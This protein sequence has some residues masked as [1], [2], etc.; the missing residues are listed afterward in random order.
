MLKYAKLILVFVLTHPFYGYA[1]ETETEE[2]LLRPS[3]PPVEHIY[4]EQDSINAY[5]EVTNIEAYKKLIPSIFSVPEKPLCMVR[6]VDFYKM[7]SGPPYLEGS[8]QILVKFKRPQSG[9][10]ILAWHFLALSVTSEEAL[11]GRITGFPKVLR[12]LT[13]ERNP[14]KYTATS[15]ARDG[16]TPA[17]KLNLEFNKARPTSDEKRFLDF[18]SPIP[19]LTIQDG[20]AFNRGAI[21]GG[22]YNIYELQSVAPQIWNIAFGD[23]T[24]EYP[25]VPNNYLSRLGIGKS[26]TGFWYKQKYKFKIQHKKEE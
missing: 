13:F 19:F 6:I 11:W 10:E 20:K 2:L 16:Q 18:V 4:L 3:R 24:I 17:L 25:S 26:I 12:K 5:F 7:E 9:E 15:F 8:V 23:C 22:K 14:N 21:A 1:L